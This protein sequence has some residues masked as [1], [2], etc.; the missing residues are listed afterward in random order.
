M[1]LFLN[2]LRLLFFFHFYNFFKEFFIDKKKTEEQE[3]E[4]LF[5]KKPKTPFEFVLSIDD[6]SIKTLP[7][8]KS[9]NVFELGFL[10]G[11][12]ATIVN[13]KRTLIKITS[14]PAKKH[15]TVRPPGKTKIENR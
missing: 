14:F 11:E 5:L 12:F 13:P 15:A 2:T 4:E 7:G 1:P 10:F 3:Q 9:Q 6:L 8:Q